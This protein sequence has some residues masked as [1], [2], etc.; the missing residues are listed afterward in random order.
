M[1]DQEHLCQRCS[2]RCCKYAALEV[3]KPKTAEDFDMF[4]SYVSHGCVVY[5][6]KGSWYF[7]APTRCRHLMRDNRCAIYPRR[8]R[9]CREHD[10]TDCENTTPHP[11]GDVRLETLHDVE[12]YAQKVLGKKKRPGRRYEAP[13]DRRER[14]FRATQNAKKPRAKRGR[15]S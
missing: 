9:I 13:W 5:R 4:R 15:S 7:E 8:P 10:A 3:D 2:A 12:A 14:T 11:H 6:E 1:A